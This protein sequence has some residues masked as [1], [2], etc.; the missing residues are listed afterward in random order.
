MTKAGHFARAFFVRSWSG[1]DSCRR[2]VR[3][4]PIL[5]E[6]PSPDDLRAGT[7]EWAQPPEAIRAGE[8][9]ARQEER[10]PA[11]R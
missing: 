10:E 1:Q 5:W 9:C 3:G 6:P 11:G 8:G 2:S 7:S 4:L